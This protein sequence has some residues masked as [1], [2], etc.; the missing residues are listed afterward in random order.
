MVG[1]TGG[2]MGP[3]AAPAFVTCP[4]S[5]L[6]C[7]CG[8]EGEVHEGGRLEETGTFLMGMIGVTGVVTVI[9]AGAVPRAG[10]ALAAA[11]GRGVAA[12]A[13]ASAVAIDVCVSPDPTDGDGAVTAAAVECCG[14]GAV[15]EVAVSGVRMPTT[16]HM[17]WPFR[18]FMR[19][20]SS[21]GMHCS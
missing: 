11:G 2:G 8:G 10:V 18:K 13:A 17:P 19:P 7:C 3:V 15:G 16:S 6:M 20:S 14:T 21:S 1:G 4:C 9:A 12:A 5:T